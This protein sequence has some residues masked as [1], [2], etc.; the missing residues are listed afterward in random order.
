MPE[1][2]RVVVGVNAHVED[3]VAAIGLHRIDPEGERRQ[4]ERTRA[5]RAARDGAA[6]ERTLA[7]VRETARGTANLLPPLRDALAAACTVGEVCGALREEW[8]TYDRPPS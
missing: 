2:E 5:V 6:A 7:T 1:G 4:V 3:K 8:G